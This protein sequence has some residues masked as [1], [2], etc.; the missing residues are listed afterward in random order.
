MCRFQ[1]AGTSASLAEAGQAAADNALHMKTRPQLGLPV[2]DQQIEVLFCLGHGR[3]RFIHDVEA[4]KMFPHVTDGRTLELGGLSHTGKITNDVAPV[5]LF[6]QEIS[7]GRL[8]GRGLLTGISR[9][10]LHTH[11]RYAYEGR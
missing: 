7:E 6:T 3:D 4:I 11:L 8:A 10:W 1:G 2:K 9:R 5:L